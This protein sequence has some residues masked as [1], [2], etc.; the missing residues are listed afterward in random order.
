MARLGAVEAVPNLRD[1]TR[2]FTFR[3]TG[4]L[5]PGPLAAA[6]AGQPVAP[7]LLLALR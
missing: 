6:E 3:P 1:A 5:Y 4:H 7:A 2:P